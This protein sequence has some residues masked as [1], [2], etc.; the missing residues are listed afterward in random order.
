MIKHSTNRIC[1]GACPTPG[2]DDRP[3]GGRADGSVLSL[4]VLGQAPPDKC[5]SYTHISFQS[6]P[7]PQGHSTQVCILRAISWYAFWLRQ[8]GG[9]AR[10]GD[11]G[12]T[13][14]PTSCDASFLWHRAPHNSTSLLGT[15]DIPEELYPPNPV[16]GTLSAWCLNAGGGE[17]WPEPSFLLCSCL[18]RT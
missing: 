14:D 15:P 10:W 6:L 16:L 5:P 3:A 18:L 8:Q 7:L 9:G 1:H 4:A 11:L 12:G 13:Q 17:R 2:K